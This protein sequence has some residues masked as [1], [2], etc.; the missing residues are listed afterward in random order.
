MVATEKEMSDVAEKGRQVTPAMR[1]YLQAKALHPEAL[2]LFRMGDFYELFWD[3]ARIVSKA[4][5][6]TLTTRDRDKNENSIPMCGVPH[7]AIDTYV[8]RLL[9]QGYKVAICDQMEDPRFAKGIVKREVTRVITPSTATDTQAMGAS[10]AN[11]LIVVFEENGIFGLALLDMLTGQFKV[12]SANSLSAIGD[13]LGRVAPTEL[14]YPPHLEASLKEAI[15][16]YGLSCALTCRETSYFTGKENFGALTAEWSARLGELKKESPLYAAVTLGALAY[17]QE[18]LGQ[19]PM[20]LNSPE[21]YTL[22]EYMQLDETCRRNLELVRTSYD[23]SVNGSLLWHLDHCKTPMGSR[24]LKHWL[25]YPLTSLAAINGRLDYVESLFTES[26]ARQEIAHFL[27]QVHD[28]ERLNG[29]LAARLAT[30]RDLAALNNSLSEIGPLTDFIKNSELGPAVKALAANIDPLSDVL[31]LLKNA[32]RPEPMGLVGGGEIFNPGY[33]S[34]LDECRDLQLHGRE[35]IL[36]LADKERQRSGISSLKIKYNKVFGYYIEIPKAKAADVPADYIRRQTT[37]NGERFITPELKELED[38]VLLA[39]E[40]LTTI[41]QQLYQDLLDKLLPLTNRIRATAARLGELDSYLS[42]AEVAAEW[43]YTRPELTMENSI[44][45]TAGRHPV[46]ER[47]SRQLGERFIAN[48]CH[49]DHENNQLLII[50]GPNM[51]GKSTMMR[52]V[53]LITLLA[54]MG[55]FVPADKAVIGIR[56]RIF[57]R[58]GASDILHKGQS[59][60]MVEM[61]ETAAILKDATPRSLIILDEIGRGTSTYDG[62]SI[63]WAIAEHLLDVTGALTL[64]ATHYH[65]LT[66]LVEERPQAQ[67]YNVLVKELN[68]QI[69]FLRRLEKGAASRSYGIQVARLAGLPESLIKRSSDILKTLESEQQCLQQEQHFSGPVVAAPMVGNLVNQVVRE[70]V[71]PEEKKQPVAETNGEKS[72]RQLSFFDECVPSEVEATLKKTDL[73]DL[74]PRAALELLY[75]LKEMC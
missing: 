45:I 17:L 70:V 4:L 16:A 66:A 69:I 20:H 60:F 18:T 13:E 57:T 8:S 5:E 48:D 12:T 63:A 29:K 37:V 71:L 55:S 32:I 28:L 1:Q 56:D 67:N 23:N 26:A 36:G 44:S 11:Y 25:L 51:A 62:L 10:E 22:A 19:I 6:L 34:E 58:V 14:L 72:T 2:L 59:T 9:S 52:Q 50:T 31:D 35:I 15:S 65:E 74:S 38:K 41:E 54:H 61:C 68:D 46:I 3:D 43:G 30:P 42:L 27:G 75:K 24:T 73:D 47:L 64:F 40:K 53:A 21:S 49:L 7:H 39:E 33:S